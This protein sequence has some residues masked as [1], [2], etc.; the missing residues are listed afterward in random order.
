MRDRFQSPSYITPSPKLADQSGCRLT[1]GHADNADK[2]TFVAYGLSAT[3][4]S[5]AGLFVFLSW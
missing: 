4:A 5:R 2:P 1:Q 3:L